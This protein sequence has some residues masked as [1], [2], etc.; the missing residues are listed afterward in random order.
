MKE[1]QSNPIAWADG[2]RINAFYQGAMQ[3]MEDENMIS[4]AQRQVGARTCI[5]VDATQLKAPGPSHK[6]DISALKC[7]YTTFTT[8]QPL[9]VLFS[10]SIM[11]KYS[12]LGT[13]LLQVKAVELA[14]VKV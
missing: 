14:L 8:P 6:I 3:I 11:R 1:L 13:F 2:E 10:A 5:R 12:R 9:R 7:L 4:E